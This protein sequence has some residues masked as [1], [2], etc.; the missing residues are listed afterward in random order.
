M[1]RLMVV[2]FLLLLMVACGPKETAFVIE[3]NF[4]ISVPKNATVIP[5]L[6]TMIDDE[7]ISNIHNGTVEVIINEE[8]YQNFEL[9]EHDSLFGDY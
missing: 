8:L 9:K 3:P 5:N 1:K 6:N 4:S 2:F 7:D